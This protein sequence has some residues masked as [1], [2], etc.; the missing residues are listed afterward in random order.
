[1]SADLTKAERVALSLFLTEYP[2]NWTFGEILKALDPDNLSNDWEQITV[3]QP[4]ENDHGL[5]IDTLQD[6]R[7]TLTRIY[8]E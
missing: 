4:L 1:M 7:D 2:D 6:T 3:W 5:I 8:G